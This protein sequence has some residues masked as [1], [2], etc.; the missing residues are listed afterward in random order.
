MSMRIRSTH[1]LDAFFKYLSSHGTHKA[2]RQKVKDDRLEVRAIKFQLVS[3]KVSVFN[4][5]TFHSG[6]K[7]KDI[8][9]CSYQEAVILSTTITFISFS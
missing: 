8:S 5:C 4:M 7:A 9:G 3:G 6:I 2:P 1:A